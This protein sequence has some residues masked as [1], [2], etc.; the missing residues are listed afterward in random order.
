VG[1]TRKTASFAGGTITLDVDITKGP[2]VETTEFRSV[3]SGTMEVWVNH[4]SQAFT[5]TQVVNYPA[6]VY[7]YCYVCLDDDSQQKEGNVRSVTQ[8]SDDVPSG[9]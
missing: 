1:Y 2:G 8:S 3:N 5:S 6:T 4:Y 7:V 9:G